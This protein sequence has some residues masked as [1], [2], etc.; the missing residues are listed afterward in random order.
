M[1]SYFNIITL[2][3]ISS[4]HLIHANSTMSIYILW[5]ANLTAFVKSFLP[6]VA[7]YQEL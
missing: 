4:D 5:V 6:H 3:S 7:A 2:F 1:I